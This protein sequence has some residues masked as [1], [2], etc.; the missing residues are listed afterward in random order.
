VL[1]LP[2]SIVTPA[3]IR[4]LDAIADQLSGT[5]RAAAMHAGVGQAMRDALAVAEQRKVLAEGDRPE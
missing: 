1:T 2:I 3:V 4:A 5:Q